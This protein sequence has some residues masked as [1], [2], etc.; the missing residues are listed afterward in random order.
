MNHSGAPDHI[1]DVAR[2]EQLALGWDD[3][4]S[5]AKRANRFFDQLWALGLSMRETEEGRRG[6]ESLL[7]HPNF[8]V[9][10]SAAAKCLAW[11]PEKAIPVLEELRDSPDSPGLHGLSAEYTLIEYREGKL[12]RGWTPT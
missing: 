10:L 7:T 11:A 2:F 4:Q 12:F 8:G 1:D 9:R 5:N 6:I 3:A